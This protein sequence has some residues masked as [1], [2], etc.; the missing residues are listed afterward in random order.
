MDI[1]IYSYV[2]VFICIVYYIY[3]VVCMYFC[4][5]SLKYFL[6]TVSPCAKTA[7]RLS[8]PC[9]YYAMLTLKYSLSL[10]LYIYTYIVI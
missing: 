10:S 1:H 5:L 6:L 7:K 2:Y 3:K 4:P 9:S 8:K